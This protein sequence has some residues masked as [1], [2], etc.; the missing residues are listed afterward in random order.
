MKI[1]YYHYVRPAPDGLPHFRYLHLD[2]FK[3]QLDML[4]K[5]YGFVKKRDFLEAFEQGGSLPEGVVLTF[6]DGFKDHV[7]YVLPE[8]KRRGIWGF[9]FISTGLYAGEK[10]LLNVHRVHNLLG[11][12]GGVVMLDALRRQLTPEVMAH[13]H[14]EEFQRETYTHQ[15]NDQATNDFKRIINYF[16]APGNQG[17][18]LDRLMMDFG[19]EVQLFDAFYM[20]A[21][22]I[23]ALQD[24]GMIVGNHSVTH[25]VFSNLSV[26]D[27]RVEIQDSFAFLDKAVGGLE[28]KA[29][30]YP[31][32]HKHTYTEETMSLLRETGC[33]MA[34][35]T[36]NRDVVRRDIEEA[37]LEL[38][39]YDCN[40]FP[41]GRASYGPY[42]PGEF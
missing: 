8:L 13:E 15:D 27:Q 19:D 9:F 34:F 28:V 7:H 10:K 3:V 42:R 4:D 20:S 37:P 2:D 32:G 39:R 36:G 25:P 5:D 30:G 1:L 12:H 33:R 18:I 35:T 22:E 14:V 11:R 23:H 41:H 17:E 21:D 6:D 26:D 31:F 40:L 38:P 29:F 24:E 16:I